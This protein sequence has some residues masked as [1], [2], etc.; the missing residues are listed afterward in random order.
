MASTAIF[1]T[2]LRPRRS[3]GL[4]STRSA[5]RSGAAASPRGIAGRPLW[6]ARR[7]CSA[8]GACARASWSGVVSAAAWG[9]LR[10]L[11][12]AARERLQDRQAR[13]RR[14]LGARAG[15]EVAVRAAHGAQPAAGRIA[16]RL[17]RQR[18]RRLR[19]DDTVEVDP[20][21]DVEVG[22]EIVAPELRAVHARGL[23]REAEVHLRRH[24]TRHTFGASPADLRDGRADLTAHVDLVAV[25]VDLQSKAVETP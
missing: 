17:H 3:P 2:R 18:E 24:V 10:S 13:V 8:C 25:L 9:L 22:V 12:V 23:R 21:V 7:A 16:E 5:G 14:A 15:I 20:I 11:L 4:C 19:L 1:T 6:W